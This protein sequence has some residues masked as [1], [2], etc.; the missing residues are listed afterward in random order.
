MLA[1][2][3]VVLVY[4]LAALTATTLVVSRPTQSALLPSLS[5]TPDEL[6]AANGTAGVVEGAGVLLGP[7][8]AAAI[9]AGEGSTPATVFLAGGGALAVAAILAF[10]VRPVSG[11]PEADDWTG[12]DDVDAISP[13]GVMAGLRTVAADA[14][15]RLVLGL[16]SARMLMVGAADVLFVLLALE[17]LT[18]GEPGAGILNAALGLGGMLGGAMTFVLVGRTGLAMVAALGA[19]AWG[20][21]LGLVAVTASAWL[22]PLLII[23]G[24]GWAGDRR[25]LR[26][27]DPA[28]LDPGR[29]P[30]TRLRAAG[31]SRD[32]RAGPWLAA[33]PAPRRS[34][35]PVHGDVGLCRDPAG[36][37][38]A[39]LAATRR[40]R[41]A[42]HPP[43]S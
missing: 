19:A 9:L 1:G 2:A 7:L 39:G 3:P 21:G 5:R 24:R 26:T 10:G 34:V 16:L 13:F 36:P 25:C 35:R 40:P 41:P 30:G 29:G 32:G 33:C 20:I 43:R 4:A 8:V 12:A 23:G 38:P 42:H 17:L 28:A 27:H 11:S 18:T 6:T 31:G 22:A 37:H 14:D 15:A